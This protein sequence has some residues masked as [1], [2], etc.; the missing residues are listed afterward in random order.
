MTDPLSVATGVAG[1][2]SLGLQVT[3]SL[4]EFYTAYKGQ[5]AD[6]A[7]TTTKV[8]GLLTIFRNLEA[9]LRERTFQPNKQDIV[10]NIESCIQTCKDAIGELQD[11]CKKLSRGSAGDIKGSLKVAGRRVAYPFR[12]ST[13][14][15]LDED[16]GEIRDNLS[17]AL[18]VLQLKDQKKAQDDIADLKL[19]L[20]HVSAS[21]LS[22]SVREWLKAPDASV[23][24]N[25]ACAKRHP[26]TGMWFINGSFFTTWLRQ[27]GSFLWLNG[28]AGCGKSLLCASAI[29]HTFRQKHSM[30]NV[31]IA[32]FYFTFSDDS[33]QDE[34]AMLRALLLQL[35]GQ[36]SNGPALLDRIRTS[37]TVATPPTDS[38]LEHLRDLIRR[39]HHVYILLDALDEC[40]RYSQRDRVLNALQEMRKWSLPGLHLLVTSRDELDIRVSLNPDQNQ[41]LIMKNAGIDQDISDFISSQLEVDPK[42]RRWQQHHGRIKSALTDRAQG[43][44]CPRSENHLDRCLRSLPRGLDE[45]Y[46]RMLCNIDEDCVEDARRILTLLCFSTR[47]LKIPEL[48][49][50]IAVNLNEP[51]GLDRRRRLHDADDIRTICPGLIEIR[52]DEVHRP[53]GNRGYDNVRVTPNVRLA[54]FSVQEYLESDRITKQKA[55]SFA[56]Q[57]GPANAEIAQ[58]YLVYL[59]EP[60]LSLNWAST[61]R[62]PLS[63]LAA[64]CWCD[65]Y[66]NAGNAMSSLNGLIL[67][68]FRQPDTLHTWMR[69]NN[70]DKAR[71]FQIWLELM[72]E[73][74]SPALPIL[75]ATFLGLDGVLLELLAL[76]EK[77]KDRRDLI[78]SLIGR[79]PLFAL[80]VAAENGHEKLVRLLL[81][82]GADVSAGRHRALRR[83]SENSHTSVVRMLLDADP[84]RGGLDE[85][86]KGAI[87]PYRVH[88]DIS[89]MLLEAGAD[90]NGCVEGYTTLLAWASL[91]GDNE[92]VQLLL[93]AGADASAVGRRDESALLL[94][95][96]NGNENVVKSLLSAGAEVNAVSCDSTALQEAVEYFCSTKM[97]QVL[98]SAGAD[99]NAVSFSR[100]TPLQVASRHAWPEGVKILLNAGADVNPKKSYR[101]TA[102]YEAVMSC[103][104]EVVK[105]LLG[106][107][108]DIDPLDFRRS[109]LH[110]ASRTGQ[111]EMVEV[112]LDAGAD[113]NATESSRTAL[114]EAAMRD[115][116]EVVEILLNAGA[117]INA[118][119]GLFDTPLERASRLGQWEV[120]EVLLNA[121]AIDEGGKARQALETRIPLK[122]EKWGEDWEG[123]T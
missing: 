82:A 56:L 120:V 47:P 43:V 28:P 111:G 73:P 39:F 74:W 42:L 102:L 49:D 89:K 114:H 60:G 69:L 83:A 21:Q 46:E 115:S 23:N 5:D 17:L 97:L 10:K 19:L 15:K 61:K 110:R 45:T 68:L 103:S 91:L 88:K 65:H 92:A 1:L 70:A 59:L 16:I 58:I 34:S 55:A 35:S 50:G 11:E 98:L 29:Q 22:T 77:T 4:F 48:I 121:G 13:L 3:E 2:L 7:R 100:C 24:H 63:L 117:D 64:Q 9:A 30:V 107:G 122:E 20:R 84:H 96:R 72:H 81:D 37:S 38:L 79:R 67:R 112:L 80:G 57:S 31:G 93:N 99:V 51:A 86:L 106:A 116:T 40:P 33:K 62:F 6:V 101:T 44:R 105:M 25:A 41:M 53:W 118:V 27:D 54:H 78:N 123:D 52:F 95:V 119:S 14:Q 71:S 113:I 8:E 87:T 18:D 36:L 66:R 108:A 26:G 75:F 85:A 104:V 109:L 12:K 94:A 90:P 76:E 32:F